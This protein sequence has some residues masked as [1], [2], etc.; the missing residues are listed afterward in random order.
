MK[1][2]CVCLG[3]KFLCGSILASVCL[4]AP[5]EVSV[6][7]DTAPNGFVSPAEFVGSSADGEFQLAVFPAAVR[8]TERSVDRAVTVVRTDWNQAPMIRLGPIPSG[9]YIL[10]VKA[11]GAGSPL[12]W[13]RVQLDMDDDSADGSQSEQPPAPQN[14]RVNVD[15]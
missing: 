7:A 8:E 12:D 1:K 15:Y 3:R 6:V 11:L 5:R 14:L 9:E 10:A 13:K 4:C 2:D